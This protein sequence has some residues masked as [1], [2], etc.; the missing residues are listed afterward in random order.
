MNIAFCPLNLK[1]VFPDAACCPS[2]NWTDCQKHGVYIRKGFHSRYIQ[3]FFQIL[4]Q[5]YRCKNPS[6]I[7]ATFSVLPPMVLRY[8][9]FFWFCLIAV[10]DAL[11]RVTPAALALTWNVGII[12]I[13]RALDLHHVLQRWIS[14]QYQELH[15]DNAGRSF[16]QMVKILTAKFGL[17]ALMNRWYHKRYPKRCIFTM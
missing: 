4:V 12:V 5:R 15:P 10:I 11:E 9:R 14:Q 16:V 17:R 13:D 8:C 3:A 7:R 2:C 1:H 6:C